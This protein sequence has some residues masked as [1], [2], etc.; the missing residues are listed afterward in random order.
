MPLHGA[1]MEDTLQR[2]EPF[3]RRSPYNVFI[4]A[5]PV[6]YCLAGLGCFWNQGSIYQCVC[7]TSLYLAVFVSVNSYIYSASYS[8]INL[9][10]Y[11]VIHLSLFIKVCMV[12][13][14]KNR[15]CS[16]TF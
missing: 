2:H 5:I 12:G 10:I 11:L 8:V 7:I 1:V 16:D 13:I 6:L 3:F 4:L 14:G 9:V 15:Q